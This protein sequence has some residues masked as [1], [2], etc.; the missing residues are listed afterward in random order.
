MARISFVVPILGFLLPCLT[1]AHPL[2]FT[3]TELILRA[4]GTFRVD[5]VCD[6]D[7]LAL[8][9]TQDA[10]D[11]GLVTTLL[12]FTPAEFEARVRRLRRLFQRRVRVRFDGAPSP[13]DVE[14][15]DYGTVKATAAEIPT[16]LGLTAR[17]TGKIPV[18][19]TN[20][21]FFASRSFSDIHLSVIDRQRGLIGQAILERGSRSNPVDLSGP[22]GS[23]ALNEIVRRY[24]LLGFTHIVPLG[25]DHVLFVLGLFLFSVRL[26]PL[27]LQV[28]AFTLAHA[29]TLAYATL[30]TVELST[31]LVEAAIAL[32]IMYV[33]IE[34]I[35]TSRLT[36][37]RPLVVFAFGLLHGLGFAGVLGELGLPQ[38]DR[39]VGLFAFNIGIELGQLAIIAAALSV[40]GWCR[41]RWWYRSRLVLPASIAIAVT[42]GVWTVERLVF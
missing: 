4:D 36:P 30:G 35:L 39:V 26:R 27:I 12:S 34:N 21:A 41:T 1:D 29:L 3:A 5:M 32:S 6:L 2:T 9:V 31:R 23:Q 40:V 8:G 33:G 10:D 7:A 11:A 13:F 14:F 42:G 18:G 20:V 37:W 38:G 19:A 15:P 17:L 28:T 16:V 24:L 25:A 22:A